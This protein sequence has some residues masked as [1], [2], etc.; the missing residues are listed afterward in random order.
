[1]RGCMKMAESMPTM[2]SLLHHST[3]PVLLDVVFEFGTQLAIV[4]HSGVAVV[5]L[6]GGEYKAVL[7]G[8]GYYF[9][10]ELLD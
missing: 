4:V 2:F 5:Y 7:L 8:V 10:E 9:F 6:A 1:M 3:P